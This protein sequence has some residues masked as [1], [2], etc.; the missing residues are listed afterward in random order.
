MNER[1]LLLNPSYLGEKIY[2]IFKIY[3]PPHLWM[4]GEMNQ[5]GSNPKWSKITKKKPSINIVIRHHTYRPLLYLLIMKKRRFH[6]S[7]VILCTAYM[8]IALMIKS[9]FQAKKLLKFK[10]GIYFTRTKILSL[11]VQMN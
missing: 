3:R 11:L 1:P 5:F 2:K 8:M 4:M 9:K 7:S 10:L 6:T